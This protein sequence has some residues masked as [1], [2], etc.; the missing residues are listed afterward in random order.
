[1]WAGDV[2]DRAGDVDREQL[3]L[4]RG[5]HVSNGIWH[6]R[7]GGVCGLRGGHISERSGN[8]PSQ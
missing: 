4:V 1:M 7:C 8:D 3:C 2:P 6:D 5:W